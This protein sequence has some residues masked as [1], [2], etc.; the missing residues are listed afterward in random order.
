MCFSLNFP[1]GT[2]PLFEALLEKG[3]L[4][5]LDLFVKS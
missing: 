4:L 1:T 5:V 3:G 2:Q